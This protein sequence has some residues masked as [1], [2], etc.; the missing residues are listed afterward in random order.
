MQRNLSS[1]VFCF[2]RKPHRKSLAVERKAL[3]GSNKFAEEPR[4]FAGMKEQA[5]KDYE[6][7]G[8]QLDYPETQ[9]A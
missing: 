3:A 9:A 5:V 7:E 4:V 2:E 1:I 6:D 8:Y